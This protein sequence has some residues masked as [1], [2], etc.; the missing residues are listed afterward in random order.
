MKDLKSAER[1]RLIVMLT[2]AIA[3]GLGSFWILELMRKGMNDYLPN[4]RRTE[5]DYYVEKFKFVKM[6][7]TGAVHYSLSGDR[8][9]HNPQE[10]SY[11]IIRPVIKTLSEQQ[12]PTTVRAERAVAEQDNSKVH[13]YDNVM[14]DRPASSKS[15]HFQI[16]SDYILVLP[17]DD[18][19]QTDKPV[20]I[21]LGLSTLT[22]TGMYVNNA[23]REFRLSSKVRGIYQP[24]QPN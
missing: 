13:L 15:E 1:L 5:P 7:S 16:K 21:A 11:E 12:P 19:M 4:I 20:E 9:A 2:V 22:G 23:T 24:P 10:P 18:V 8:F 6:T 17:D 3:L 14:L